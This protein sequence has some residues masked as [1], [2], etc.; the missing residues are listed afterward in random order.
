MELDKFDIKMIIFLN[1]IVGIWLIIACYF[2]KISHKPYSLHW[3]QYHNSLT[4]QCQ[5]N[6][7][8]TAKMAC[9][10]HCVFSWCHLIC[11]SPQ[12]IAV[13]AD[14]MGR[15]NGTWN[16][17]LSIRREFWESFPRHWLQKKP[18]VSDPSMHQGTC[19]TDIP[20]CMSESL[21]RGEL[22]TP[23]GDI[24]LV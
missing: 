24:D 10:Y 9:C 13:V 5:R 15:W 21:T 22:M 18:L 17:G 2:A 8:R 16:C 14:A 12:M 23:Y 11:T 20:W 7:T 19:V 4:P 3:F 6:G 1:I